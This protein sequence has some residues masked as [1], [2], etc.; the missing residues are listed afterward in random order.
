MSGEILIVC[1]YNMFAKIVKFLKVSEFW[2]SYPCITISYSWSRVLL[3]YNI[4]RNSYP[5]L[6]NGTHD[7]NSGK[8]HSCSWTEDTQLKLWAGNSNFTHDERMVKQEY[9]QYASLLSDQWRSHGGH[10]EVTWCNHYI[11]R[12]APHSDSHTFSY[13]HIRLSSIRLKLPFHSRSFAYNS[14]SSW[15]PTCS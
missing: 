8:Y 1:M 12:S 5:W 3:T 2:I 15:S 10:M 4:R 11:C 14:G 9:S 13:P 6:D 7:C